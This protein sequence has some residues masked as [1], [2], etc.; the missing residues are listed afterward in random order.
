[1]AIR[2]YMN[3]KKAPQLFVQA[4]SAAFDDPAHFP[5]T[6]GF[7]AYRTEG[8]AYARYILQSKPGAKIA[9]LYGSSAAGREY[10]AGLHD[11][12]GGKASTM[13]AKEVSYE[14]TDASLASQIAALKGSG[15]DVFINLALGKFATQAIRRVYDIGWRPLQF[16]PNASLSTAAFL[17]SGGPQE[18]RWNHHERPLQGLAACAGPTRPCCA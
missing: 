10:L 8:S 7:F 13:I 12:L 2:K 3:D 5:W 16:I 15:A 6:M 17:E 9:V 18:S 1:M 14:H 11:G 4:S